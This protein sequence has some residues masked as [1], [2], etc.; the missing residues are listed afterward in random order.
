MVKFRLLSPKR[1]SVGTSE[2]GESLEFEAKPPKIG[3]ARYRVRPSPILR[4]PPGT[5]AGGWGRG[6]G[7]GA[8]SADLGR[9]ER[10]D[11]PPDVA[12]GHLPTPNSPPK[13]AENRDH[14]A[15]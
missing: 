15:V 14:R 10:G 3:G 11:P 7:F 2:E 1:V 8:I 6:G 12:C 5:R 4:L 13:P 9:G